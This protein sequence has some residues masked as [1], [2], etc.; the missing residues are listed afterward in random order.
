MEEETS[1]LSMRWRAVKSH[2]ANLALFIIGLV[3][4]VMAPVWRFAVAPA[5]KVVATD[6]DRITFS[7]GTLATYVNPPGGARIGVTPLSTPVTLQQRA[8][9]PIG[10]STTDVALL[11]IDSQLIRSDDRV[12]LSQVTHKYAIDRITARQVPGHG[13]DINRTGYY[14]VFPFDTPAADIKVW[15]N[16][17][18]TAR[19]AMFVRKENGYGINVYAFT[20]KYGGQSVP[21]PPGFPARMTGA[22]L[23]AVLPETQ[24]AL[25][26]ADVLNISF[27]GNLTTEFLVE[28][29]SGS[30]VGVK[31]NGQSVFMSVED[32]TRGLSFTQV[33]Y[34]LDYSENTTSLQAGANFAK[35]EIAKINLQFIYLP[36]GFLLLGIACTLIGLFAH[37]VEDEG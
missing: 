3:L 15:D 28:P 9:N 4:I 5:I 18:E 26:D 16:L 1:G 2:R 22:Q 20:M 14:Y 25:G 37:T 17:S 11:Q 13:S 24:A 35:D 8:F 30:L 36:L 12:R 23:K 31:S 7:A 32:T 27:K 21:A 19:T 29:V 10:K 33:V 34:K 6:F